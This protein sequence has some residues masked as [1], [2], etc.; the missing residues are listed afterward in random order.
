MTNSEAPKIGGEAEQHKAAVERWYDLTA[1]AQSIIESLTVERD[2]ALAQVAAVAERTGMSGTERDDAFYAMHY[3]PDN[4]WEVHRLNVCISVPTKGGSISESLDLIR[5]ILDD[6][7]FDI[8]VT[9][10]AAHD[11][12]V[13][14]E[15]RERIAAAIEADYATWRGADK[16]DPILHSPTWM[17]AAAYRSAARIARAEPTDSEES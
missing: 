15:E 17:V 2:E 10:L 1:E 6:A 4:G 8:R 3:G 7:A 12:Q 5:E 11:A 13:R 9:V 16:A 14:A